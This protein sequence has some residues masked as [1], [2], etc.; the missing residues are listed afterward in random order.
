ME[1]SRTRLNVVK[2]GIIVATLATALI[3][4]YLAVTT[5]GDMM[6]TIMFTLNFLAY[7]GLLAAYFLPIPF[8]QRMHGLV[9]YALLALAVVT[10]LLWALMGMRIPIAYVD[11]AFEVLLVVLLLLDK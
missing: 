7:T 8:F 10:I 11:K 1:I 6:T 9:R 2:I 3:H 4:L 5:T